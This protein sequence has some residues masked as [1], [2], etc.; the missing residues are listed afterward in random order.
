LLPNIR[1]DAIKALLEITQGNMSYTAYTQQLNAF[2]RRSRQYLADDLQCVRF[3]SEH[4]NFQLRTQAKAHLSQRGYTLPLV[5]PQNFLNDIVI[6][7]PHLGRVKSTLGP[8]TTHEDGQPDK[9]RTYEDSLFGASKIWERDNG[10][11]FSRG[12]G[13]GGGRGGRGRTSPNIGRIDFNA[14]VGALTLEERTH[15][16][17]EGLCFKCHKTGHRLFQC[18]E[19]KGKEAMGASSKKQ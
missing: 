8:W 10:V 14:I 11:G 3:I 6:D 1:D 16:I 18:P 12:R 19:L 9:K 15:H 4:A 2:L 5:E 13:R 7:S 17:Q